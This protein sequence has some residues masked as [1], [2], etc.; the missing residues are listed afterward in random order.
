M[1]VKRIW[2]IVITF[3]LMI[4]MS[5]LIKNIFVAGVINFVIIVVGYMVIAYIRS[6]KRLNLL[7][8]NCN[9]QSFIEATEKQILIT[10]KNHKINMYL[11]IDKAAGL[12]V[13]GEFQEALEILNTI[14]QSCLSLKN[15]TLLV[16]TLNLIICFYELGDITQAEEIFETQVPLLA[17]VNRR[18]VLAM[19]MLVAE[20]YFYINKY[21]ESKE[22][23]QQLLKEQSSR[24]TQ[25]E[26]LFRLA[27]I[28]E[29]KGNISDAKQ[30]YME[31]AEKG[32]ELWVASQA[33][34][35]LEHR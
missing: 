23:F 22:Q 34:K 28:E 17:P 33:R 3:V 5:V 15:G 14:D 25:M 12:I 26:I 11:C 1:F 18:M 24:R 20:R 35:T 10:G 6:K 9:P 29:V 13:K 21:E 27:Q 19:K 7:E 31:V 16:Y 30:K 32:G 2:L 4:I 8:E